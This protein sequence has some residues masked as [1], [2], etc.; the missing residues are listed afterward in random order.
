MLSRRFLSFAALK[1]NLKKYKLIEQP[2]GLIVGTVN[3]P[4]PMPE[5]DY[6]HGAYHWSYERMLAVSLI[7]LTMTPFV[8]NIDLPL[9]DSLM[10]VSVLMHSHIGFQA[11]IIDYIPKRV[12]GIWHKYA[13]GLLTFGTVVSFY[14]IYLIETTDIGLTNMLKKLWV[15][16]E[17]PINYDPKQYYL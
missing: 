6:F 11:C 5:V 14:G 15:L 13:M 17:P 2:V 16:Q 1:P 7:P 12:Y 4:T 10:S 8:A 9:I 3:E